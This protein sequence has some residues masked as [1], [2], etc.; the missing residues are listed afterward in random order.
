MCGWRT[1]NLL[2]IAAPHWYHGNVIRHI[3]GARLAEFRGSGRSV[4]L[5]ESHIEPQRVWVPRVMARRSPPLAA[6][7]RARVRIGEGV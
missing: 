1:V 5:P 6:V 3:I 7:S 4:G 2:L